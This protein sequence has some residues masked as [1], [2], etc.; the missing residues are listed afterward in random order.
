[1]KKKVLAVAVALVV[2]ITAAG[3]CFAHRRVVLRIFH[4]HSRPEIKRYRP[5]D[6]RLKPCLP[7]PE[8]SRGFGW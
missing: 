2:S 7:G 1:M 4:L 8:H 6:T 5:D 3:V